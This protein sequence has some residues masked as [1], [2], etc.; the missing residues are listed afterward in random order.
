MKAL[1]LCFWVTQ[2]F[3]GLTA[4]PGAGVDWTDRKEY[5]LVLTI[6]SQ[7][8][9]QKRL[10]LLDSWSQAY[11]K[12]GLSRARL[13]LYLNTY[14]AL[15]D[16]PHMFDTAKQILVSQSDDPI[17][18]YWVTVLTPQQNNPTQDTLAAGESAARKLL[19]E[20]DT[21]FATSKKPA[22]INDADWQK[23]KL[24]VE[25]L[26]HRTIGWISWQRANL[27]PAEEEL[28]L[29][30]QKAPGYAEISSWLGIIFAS[31]GHKEPVA[32]WHLAR[33]TNK[34]LP[35]PLPEEQ[36]RQVNTMLE[37]MYASYH[38]SA[39]DLDQLR[40]V[41]LSS[42]I[43][44][45][46]FNID[47]AT[48]VNARKAEMVLSQTNP[49]LAA[50]LSIRRQLEAPEGD[51]Y[52]A[53]DVQGKVLPK[54]HGTVIHATPLR[55]PRELILSMT[56]PSSNE[57][58]SPDV[59]LKL[60]APLARPAPPGSTISFQGTGESYTKAPF[61]LVVTADTAELGSAKP[62]TP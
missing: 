57:P 3:S 59:T 44:P 33:A 14:Q 36:R 50:W 45:A 11:P 4:A 56:E 41:S 49:E 18:L 53:S 32:L 60:S 35:S 12:T 20:N 9:P 47:S 2:F 6:R 51:K 26:A 39:D 54:L 46:Q 23:Q 21:N 7:A 15:G 58:S 40:K 43:P 5:D 30:L 16:Q 55:T 52:F 17:G 38:G 27:G 61:A 22:S 28:T 42:A 19:A 25:V 13:E 29:C 34:E 10:T 48:I 62:K 8:S 31:D 24:A 1:V 37:N